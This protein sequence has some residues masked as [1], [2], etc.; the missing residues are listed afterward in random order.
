VYIPAYFFKANL[1]IPAP[2]FSMFQ[3]SKSDNIKNEGGGNALSPIAH[4]ILTFYFYH[5]NNMH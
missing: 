4:L 3:T 1:K 2:E 5:F